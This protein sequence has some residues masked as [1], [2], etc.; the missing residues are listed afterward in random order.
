MGVASI[1]VIGLYICLLKDMTVFYA[2]SVAGCVA[3]ALVIAMTISSFAGTV[4]PLFFHRIRVDP[5][6]AS[7]PLI[8]TVNDLV[9]VIAYYGTAWLLLIRVLRLA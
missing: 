9:A 1:P 3:A 6:V 4:I 8:T 7:G 5:A 2:F